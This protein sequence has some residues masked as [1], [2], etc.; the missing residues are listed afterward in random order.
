MIR[1]RKGSRG[2]L[3]SFSESSVLQRGSGR[4]FPLAAL[5]FALFAGS[6]VS[7][8]AHA[9]RAEGSSNW[10]AGSGEVGEQSGQTLP[11]YDGSSLMPLN[12]GRILEFKKSTQ[13]QFRARGYVR[14]PVVEVYPDRNS[15][16]HFSIRIGE[17]RTDSKFICS[18]AL[19]PG[20][21][22]SGG[23]RR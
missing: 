21:G 1:D 5:V 22:G 17:G 3:G 13:N 8:A 23:M 19:G 2:F 9:D 16:D 7:P 15:H 10:Q 20:T 12:N 11:C 6:L 14:G 18:G 4:L